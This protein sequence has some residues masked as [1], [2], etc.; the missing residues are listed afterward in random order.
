MR[1]VEGGELAGLSNRKYSKENWNT[2]RVVAANKNVTVA[3]APVMDDIYL[4]RLNE[5]I[6]HLGRWLRNIF[7][8]CLDLGYMSTPLQ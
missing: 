5:V 4:A 6:V 3:K 7:Q 1:E 8:A 2:S